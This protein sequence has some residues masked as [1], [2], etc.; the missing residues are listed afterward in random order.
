[1]G[2][3]LPFPQLV[4]LSP[5]LNLLHVLQPSSRFSAH[6][7]IAPCNH[8]RTTSRSCW[9]TWKLKRSTTVVGSDSTPL[10]KYAQVKLAHLPNVL[11]LLYRNSWNYH[12]VNIVCGDLLVDGKVK[13]SVLVSLIVRFKRDGYRSPSTKLGMRWREPS[14]RFLYLKKNINS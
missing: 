1:M 12:L 2:V 8:L 10:K 4:S 13:T 5:T 14:G 3:Q 6:A 11:G 7:S 9:K